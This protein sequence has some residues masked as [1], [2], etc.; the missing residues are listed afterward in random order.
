M[1]KL[2]KTVQTVYSKKDFIKGLIEGWIDLYGTI[3]SK[4]S[5]GVIYSQNMIETG[6]KYFWGNNVGNSKVGA[7][8][9]NKVIEYQMLKNVWEIEN[10]KRVV[11]QPPHRATWFRAF[12]TLR[13]GVAHHFELLK[14]KRY[15]I[16][17]AAVE[18]GDPSLFA[19]LLKKQGYY[20]APE[21][22]YV[23]G[24]NR[25]FKPYMKSNDYE[26]AL[27]EIENIAPPLEPWVTIDVPPVPMGE[28]TVLAED[29]GLSPI[30]QGIEEAEQIPQKEVEKM[31]EDLLTKLMGFLGTAAQWFKPKL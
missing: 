28:L 11:Y 29:L 22:D 12:P 10:G 2:V 25:F 4:E 1:F 16:A 26:Y 31:G 18:K 7:D 17:W 15:K 14:N 9:P 6:G 5:I 21:K 20:T 3:P 13:E 23:A 19:H 8:D 24:M 30:Q 27:A